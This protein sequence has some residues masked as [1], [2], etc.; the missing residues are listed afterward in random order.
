MEAFKGPINLFKSACP[1]QI[2]PAGDKSSLGGVVASETKKQ[3]LIIHLAPC[4]AS[5][6]DLN[7][8]TPTGSKTHSQFASYFFSG[9]IF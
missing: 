3:T 5:E 6:L 7:S 8:L 9:F 2:S 1:M 4:I